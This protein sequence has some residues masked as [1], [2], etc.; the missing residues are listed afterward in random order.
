[1]SKK[2][3]LL[4]AVALLSLAGAEQVHATSAGSSTAPSAAATTSTT[5]EQFTESTRSLLA[6]LTDLMQKGDELPA[7][8][9]NRRLLQETIAEIGKHET[10]A[11]S[12]GDFEGK[13]DLLTS[14]T[15]LRTALKQLITVQYELPEAFELLIKTVPTL[16]AQ[17]VDDTVDF[18]DFDETLDKLLAAARLLQTHLPSLKDDYETA[19]AYEK[20]LAYV[21]DVEAYVKKLQEELYAA[22]GEEVLVPTAPVYW[23]QEKLTPTTPPS[24]STDQSSSTAPSSSSEA[25]SV[26]SASSTAPSSSETKTETSDKD[27]DGQAED[28]QK[29]GELPP[30]TLPGGGGGTTVTRRVLP[31][32]N[33]QRAALPKTG[34][35][36]SSVW[37]VL[38]LAL[39]TLALVVWKGRRD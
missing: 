36:L 34:E 24:S 8:D 19:E 22:V 12:L 5:V 9:A 2:S 18:H 39:S 35:H 31:G 29:D 13:A 16:E 27:S 21:K 23:N 4:T 38:G 11:K 20:D 7:N 6:K 25:S 30:A 15:E 10:Q 32:T 37:A 17:R 14:L 26:T 28:G 33:E 3:L 1:M